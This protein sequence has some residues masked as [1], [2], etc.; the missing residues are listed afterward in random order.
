MKNGPK[1]RDAIGSRI[2][3][4]ERSAEHSDSDLPLAEMMFGVDLLGNNRA[5]VEKRPQ[6]GPRLRTENK[7]VINDYL[8]F[9]RTV[10]WIPSHSSKNCEDS[11]QT[12]PLA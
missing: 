7:S 11:S 2:R 12:T 4:S 10:A 8:P 6:N 5:P 3:Q 9:S 1:R